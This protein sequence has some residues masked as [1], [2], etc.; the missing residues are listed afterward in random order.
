MRTMWSDGSRS[1]DQVTRR[2]SRTT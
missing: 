2:H 1:I